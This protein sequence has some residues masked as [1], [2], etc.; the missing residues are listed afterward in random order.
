MNN[1]YHYSLNNVFHT[2]SNK[3]IHIQPTLLSSLNEKIL[4]SQKYLLKYLHDLFEYHNIDY[5]I[6]H[7]TLLGFHLFQGI[8]IFYHQIELIMMYRN[9]Q[10]L[11]K[12]LKKDGFIIDFES[13]YLIV[14]SSTFFDKIQIKAFIYLL[15]SHENNRLYHLSPH[16]VSSSKNYKDLLIEKESFHLTFIPFQSIFPCKKVNYEDFQIFI[17]N[18]YQNILESLQLKQENYTFD[19]NTIIPKLLKQNNQ[20]HEE[21][22]HEEKPFYSFLTSLLTSQS[23]KE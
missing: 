8:H 10:D 18:Q 14:I 5:S 2:I 19:S 7:N 9:F 17:P 4:I 21:N 6:Y 12:E 1:S 20:N 11:Y 13:K 23:P 15:H 22:H 16:F 3:N